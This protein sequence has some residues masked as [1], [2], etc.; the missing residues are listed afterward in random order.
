MAIAL[1]KDGF[2]SFWG[3]SFM[4]YS[5]DLQQKGLVLAFGLEPQD[6]N[7]AEESLLGFF[8]T[9]QKIERRLIQEGKL[10]SNHEL[11]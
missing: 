9:L 8:S 11:V 10:D 7:E 3:P 5:S 2:P 4:S 1:F 6:I